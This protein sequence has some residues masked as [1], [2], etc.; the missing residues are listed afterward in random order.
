MNP[1]SVC[2]YRM[3]VIH[4][5]FDENNFKFSRFKRPLGLTWPTCLCNTVHGRRF[6]GT[7][8]FSFDSEN[9]IACSQRLNVTLS[10]FDAL[11]SSDSA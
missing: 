10:K 2:M 9:G 8:F 11:D 5:G 1:P 4:E 7:F 3:N 6:R